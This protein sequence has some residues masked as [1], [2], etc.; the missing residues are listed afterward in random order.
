MQIKK[1][2]SIIIPALNES[3]IIIKNVDEIEVFLKGISHVD[4]EVIVVDDGSTDGMHTLLQESIRT[5]PWLRVIKHHINMGRG[6]GIR[7]GFEHAR[8]D[9]I[10]C[11]DADLSYSP[12]HI[13]KLILPLM[14]NEADITLASPYHHEGVVENVPKQRAL[15]SRWGNK[16]LS[17][18]LGLNLSTVTCIVRGFKRE[19]VEQLELVNNGKELHLEILHKAK[20]LNLRV[21][22]V[23]AALIWRDKQ[24]G[25]TKNKLLPEIAIFKMRK[26]V[27]SH[28][29][30]NFVSNPGLILSIPILCLTFIILLGSGALIYAFFGNLLSMKMG[31]LQTFRLTLINGQL[32]LLMV[33]FS[34]VFLMLFL[35]FYFISF[36]MKYYFDEL[37]ILV[38]RINNQLKD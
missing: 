31:F 15:L 34:S 24:R 8:G 20:L 4:Y 21:K 38:N 10:V 25:K 36:Q 1:L 13:E 9:Y 12:E 26:T 30:F 18:G 28:L 32:S 35:A 5:R 11:L 6:K 23:P 19:V 29:I 7:T 3:G 27:F 22:E 14:N 37:Y 33:L 17:K 2:I 16:I